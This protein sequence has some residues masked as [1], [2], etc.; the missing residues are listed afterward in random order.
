MQNKLKIAICSCVGLFLFSGCSLTPYQSEFSCTKGVNSGVCESVS[1]NYESS[2]EKESIENLDDEQD[3]K[4]D[5][6]KKEVFTDAI[7]KCK[8]KK[9][10]SLIFN[11]DKN[12]V[13]QKEEFEKCMSSAFEH[14]ADDM[15]QANEEILY[16]QKLEN[17]R[18]LQ[19]N[20]LLQAKNEGIKN[21]N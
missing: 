20:S 19:K 11:K 18:L 6:I 14:I 21:E 9:Q 16:Y 5:D 1:N 2:F 4:E 3:K 13:Y 10:S 12:N 7:G 8:E 15:K 17:E